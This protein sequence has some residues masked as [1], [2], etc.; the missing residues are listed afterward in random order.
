MLP[1]DLFNLIDSSFEDTINGNNSQDFLYNR[2]EGW[3]SI[4]YAERFRETVDEIINP[5]KEKYKLNIQK[6]STSVT[7]KDGKFVK[8]EQI[9]ITQSNPL[10]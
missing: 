10:T 3:V 2:S 9:I 8:K 6:Y 7:I 4:T 5:L 1:K